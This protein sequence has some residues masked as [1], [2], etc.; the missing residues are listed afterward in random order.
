MEKSRFWNDADQRSAGFKSIDDYER[1]EEIKILCPGSGEIISVI[2]AG[3][4]VDMHGLRGLRA[5][6]LGETLYDCFDVPLWTVVPDTQHEE[7]DVDDRNPECEA[8]K[9][10]RLFPH[11]AKPVCTC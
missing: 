11:Q 8:H 1:G 4:Y 10:G 5:H 6:R 7:Y 2:V 9:P 3:R